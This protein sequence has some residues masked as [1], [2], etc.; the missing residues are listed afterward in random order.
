MRAWIVSDIH[1]TRI[2]ALLGNNLSVPEAEVC[3]CAGDITNSVV[4]SISYVRRFIE[5]HMPVV[6]TL[7][8][9]DYYGASID[10]A[11]ER[12]RR[13]GEGTH[14]QLLENQT[15]IINDCRFVGATLW[16]DFAVSVGDDEHLSPEERRSLAL[17][18]VPANIADFFEIYRSDERP[19]NE[20]GMITAKEILS[21]HRSSRAYID[22]ELG[23]PFSGRTVVLTHHAPHMK[24]LDPRFF[25][26][27]TSAAFVS[28]LSDLIERRRP[29]VWVHGHVHRFRDY[30][31]SKTRVICNPHGYGGERG[32]SGF[33]PGFVIDL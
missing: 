33:R 18:V 12:A 26:Q 9:H 31:A 8:N 24:S 1:H 28:D 23:V 16:T 21:R 32:I 7:G 15:A 25:G 4:D 2:D 5:P 19:R 13:L 6:L 14:I 10:F 30:M 22:Q 29:D 27:V 17:S 11:L 20:N 3:I